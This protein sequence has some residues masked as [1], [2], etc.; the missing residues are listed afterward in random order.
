MAKS[1]NQTSLY[2]TLTGS[3][4]GF[5]LLFFTYWFW[6]DP[7]PIHYPQFQIPN[8]IHFTDGIT[9]CPT[10]TTTTTTD[11]SHDPENQTFYDDPTISFSIEKSITNWDEKRQE[12][13][14]LHPSFKPGVSERILVLTG[15]QPKPCK[16]PIGD[17][18][19]LRLFKNK[20]DYC[21]IHGYEI[22]YSNTFLQKKMRSFWAKLPVVK[23]AM[24]AHP[25]TE[26]IWW[27]DSDAVFTDMEFKAPLDRYLDY[28]LVVHG[29]PDMVF[30]QKSWVGANAGV[31]LIR[32]CQWS[33][34]F[35]EVWASMGPQSPDFDKWGKIQK[36]TLP[37]KLF[38]ASDDQSGLIYL[39]LKEREKWGEKIFI[40]S[41]YEL[42]GYWLGIVKRLANVSDMYEDMERWVRRLRRRYA[43]TNLEHY[44]VLREKYLA[45][46]GVGSDSW[47]RPFITHF[48]GCQQCS[49]DHNPSYGGDSCWVGM[50]M[51]LN[52][53]DNQVLRSYGFVHPDVLN[54]S[55]VW[56]L[57]FD[58]PV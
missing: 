38:P 1:N 2:L 7:L 28:N 23:A 55:L 52:F 29:W 42:S 48:T 44:A 35:M 12:W 19:Q 27:V 25:E 5:L 32:N 47:R 22:F 45:G 11:R 6:P 21:R 49:G 33:M 53:A 46:A 43:E 40:E 18:L 31:F 51:A 8:P 17:H 15:S 56:P 41:D 30:G 4:L 26:W 16:N 24:M 3:I 34:D 58:Y 50:E 57:S 13:L 37:D 9:S 14:N 10:T 20:V 39:I 36:S 54:G